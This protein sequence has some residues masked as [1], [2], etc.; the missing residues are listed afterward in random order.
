MLHF[1]KKE[2]WQRHLCDKSV[3]RISLGGGSDFLTRQWKAA[4]LWLRTSPRSVAPRIAVPAENTGDR[5]Y[6]VGRW[7]AA[8][9]PTAATGPCSPKQSAL[10]GR[11]GSP[12]PGT[13][14]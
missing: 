13:A 4:D 11:F 14:W 12:G 3:Q 1:H 2:M 7:R 9:K 10:R 5:G 8:G 6:I